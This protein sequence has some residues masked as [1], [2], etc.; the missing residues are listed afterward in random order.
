MSAQLPLS[1][2]L[3]DSATF[4]NFLVEK[5]QLIIA[6][7]QQLS[8]PYLYLWGNKG[9]GKSHLLQ[10]VCHAMSEQQQASLYLPLAQLDE[11]SPA[12]LD[13]LE[14]LQ[15][16]CL[17]DVQFL[18]N[19]LDWQTALFNLYNQVRHSGAHLVVAADTAPAGL[20]LQ[21][22]DLLSRL[23]WGPVFQLHSLSDQ[24]KRQALQLRATA[25]GLSLPDDVAD[26]LLKRCPRD[27]NSLFTLLETLDEASLVAQRKLTIPF[28]RQFI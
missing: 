23:S 28:V 21:L 27:M 6:A 20:A 22:P 15:L 12:M 9:S 1:I 11:F 24:G 4:S 26:Y 14:Q 3:Q 13:G 18:A 16:I 19:R 5:N 8:E 2:R 17:D 10:A 7:L 25:R